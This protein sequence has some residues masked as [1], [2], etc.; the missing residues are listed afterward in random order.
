MV[1][2]VVKTVVEADV[3][4]AFVEPAVLVEDV[5]ILDDSVGLVANVG[6]VPVKPV[7]VVVV[8]VRGVVPTRFWKVR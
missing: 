8:D 2:P 7:P 5:E 3:L 6:V 4:D 1:V